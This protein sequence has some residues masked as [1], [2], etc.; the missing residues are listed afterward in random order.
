MKIER[1]QSK[2]PL[3]ANAKLMFKGIMFDTYQWEVDGYD[4]S[5]SSMGLEIY[6]NNS[7]LDIKQIHLVSINP[8]D[9]INIKSK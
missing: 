3:P 4:G 1:P 7:K 9:L 6:L 2:Q 5:K 8:G